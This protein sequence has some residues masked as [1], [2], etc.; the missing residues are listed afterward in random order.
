M[1][2]GSVYYCTYHSVL[3]CSV[4]ARV[5]HGFSFDLSAL[6]VAIVVFH[7]EKSV[8]LVIWWSSWQG[9][10]HLVTWGSVY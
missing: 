9:K 3:I 2:W 4:T 5:M 6:V 1:T 10:G 8:I 7:C